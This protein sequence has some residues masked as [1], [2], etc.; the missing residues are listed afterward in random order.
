MTTLVALQREF[1]IQFARGQINPV[2]KWL[3]CDLH[4]ATS[5][6]IE[7]A[8]PCTHCHRRVGKSSR[9]CAAAAT[10]MTPLPA[11]NRA[12]PGS[13]ATTHLC[14]PIVV[15]SELHWTCRARTRPWVLRALLTGV[16]EQLQHCRQAD[17]WLQ[18]RLPPARGLVAS[19]RCATC[20]R[21]RGLAPAGVAVTTQLQ[22][23]TATR[24]ASF[25]GRAGVSARTIQLLTGRSCKDCNRAPTAPPSGHHLTG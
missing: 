12:L 13:H 20:G 22:W 2:L 6:S 1:D 5:R 3:G 24:A 19:T 10:N 14:N 4:C 21:R 17:G 7:R 25:T 9:G 15:A 18:P 16:S 23:P 11:C 8:R